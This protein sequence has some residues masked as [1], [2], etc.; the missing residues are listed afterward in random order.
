M[1]H[2]HPPPRLVVVG[3]RTASAVL[4]TYTASRRFRQGVRSRRVDGSRRK[5]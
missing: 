2:S 5:S 4:K 1:P 3:I